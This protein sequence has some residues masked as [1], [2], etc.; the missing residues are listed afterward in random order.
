MAK[1]VKFCKSLLKWNIVCRTYSIFLQAA[2][3]SIFFIPMGVK[4]G[5]LKTSMQ[6]WLF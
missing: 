2:D 1:I 5:L 3:A 6:L 4:K